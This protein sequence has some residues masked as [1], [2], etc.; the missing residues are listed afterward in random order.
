MVL[1]AVRHCLILDITLWIFPKCQFP[2]MPRVTIRQSIYSSD[3][4]V[5]TLVYTVDRGNF[6]FVQ[7]A[8][9]IVI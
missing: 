9:L 4:Y 5:L 8:P 1:I 7:P 6:V 2:D 3:V